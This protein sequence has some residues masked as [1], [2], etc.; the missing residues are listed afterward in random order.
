MNDLYL[1]NHEHGPR[2][3]ISDHLHSEKYRLANEDYRAK[4]NR[5]A[6][7]LCDDDQHFHNYRDLTL[8]MR[9][10]EA[11]RIQSA[12]G[13]PR[14][15]TPYNCFVSGTIEDS[16]IDGE[17][18][19]MARASEAAETMR[20]GGGIGYDFSTLRPNGALIKSLQSR[21]SGPV[22]FMKIFDAVGRCV[23][24]SGHR[25]GAQM[26]VLRIDHP[27]VMEF[28]LAKQ[29]LTELQGFNISLGVT[30]RFMECLETGR[31][32]P[33]QWQDRI[34]DEVDPHELWEMIMRSTWDWADPGVLFIDQ[35]N[36]LN[37]LY[38]CETIAATN[39]CGEQPLP[40][41]GAC[42]LGSF[43]L[44]RYIKRQQVRTGW[45][46]TDIGEEF[47][48]DWDLFRHDIPIVVRALDNVVDRAT[49]PLPQQEAEAK[50]KRRMGLGITGLANAGEALGNRY[51]DA[52]F[53]E[54]E[55]EV[56]S[57]LQEEAY[58]ASCDLAAEKGPFPLFDKELYLKGQFVQGLSDKVRH[59]IATKGIRNSHL[60]SIAPTG[61]I[62]FTADYV[63][64]GC[65]PVFEHEGQRLVNFSEGE[66]IVKVSDYAFREW[67]I[68]GKL[69]AEVTADEHLDVLSAATVLVDSAVSKTCNVD[70]TM[71]WEDFKNLYRKAYDLGAKGCTTFNKD[72][73]KMGIL[74]GKA[75]NEEDDKGAPLDE[76][77]TCRIDPLTGEKDCG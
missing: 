14:Q 60:L 11:G 20:R 56:L 9:F 31:E 74:M 73:K 61:T 26:G 12:M 21:S 50:A 4:C 13:S 62:S 1:P 67:G 64:S 29:N 72:G 28:I 39:P 49:Y 55:M 2:L 37:N 65:E 19:I 18:A 40:P 70:K 22:S 58:L 53:I 77:A 45:E 15:V 57:V 71:P 66:R 46:Q 3:I 5:V 25:R 48:F 75:D 17:G 42:L 47:Y 76:N 10:L 68:K 44:V 69:A 6:A 7:S 33:L 41:Y 52:R 54:F 43:N 30:D 32:F 23:A 51:G 16:F 63:S 34:Y 36:R 38:Y 59:A 35:I 24:S 8:D 27:D